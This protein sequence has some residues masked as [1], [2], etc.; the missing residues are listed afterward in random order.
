MHTAL[1]GGLLD[2]VMPPVPHP[3]LSPLGPL[4]WLQGVPG[5]LSTPLASSPC[6]AA[7]SRSVWRLLAV[8][9]LGLARG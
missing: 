5:S 9:G 2:M 8:L 1:L 6:A 3:S 4:A 7:P